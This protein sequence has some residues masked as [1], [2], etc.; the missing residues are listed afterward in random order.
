[1]LATLT[2]P[3]G[4]GKGFVTEYLL[5]RFP[6]IQELIWTTTRLLRPT[7]KGKTNR[8]RVEA[9]EFLARRERERDDIRC[10]HQVHGHWYGLSSEQIN[11]L[12]HAVFLTEAHV[13]NLGDV[14]R[15]V[16]SAPICAIALVTDDLQLLETRLRVHRKTKSDEEVGQRLAAATRELLYLCD[17]REAFDLVVG[18]SSANESQIAT[19]IGDFLAH[20]IGGHHA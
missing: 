4:I 1:M 2:G 6:Q 5:A 3:S 7:E 11:R 16:R 10:T 9:E 14:R 17:H 12:N 8:L 20:R 15:V 19:N 13:D 18:V